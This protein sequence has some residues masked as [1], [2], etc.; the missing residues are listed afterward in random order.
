MDS[1]ERVTCSSGWDYFLL[2][3]AVVMALYVEQ[4]EPRHLE[5]TAVISLNSY[6]ATEFLCVAPVPPL[7]LFDISLFCYRVL[8]PRPSMFL[9]M[10]QTVVAKYLYPITKGTAVCKSTTAALRCRHART[11]MP[12]RPHVPMLSPALTAPRAATWHPG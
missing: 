7:R 4:S 3:L 11:P 5:L 10:I 2:G 6:V 1:T 9:D 8:L 12:C